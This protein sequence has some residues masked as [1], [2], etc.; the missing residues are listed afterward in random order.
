MTYVTDTHPLVFFAAGNLRRL[1]ARCTRIFRRAEQGRDRVHVPSVCFF[2]IA[3]L[4]E[5]ERVQ[6]TVGFD[7]WYD[8]VTGQPGFEVEPLVWEDVREARALA[9]L[10][11][12][13][14]R[15]IA[16]TAVR[17]GA[18][19]LTNDERIRSSGLVATIW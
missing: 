10:V 7:G 16:G 18:S 5:R 17:I 14:D 3:L 13:F 11:D 8:L 9:A 1:S 19:L 15:L 6:S 12:P 4:M 2:E